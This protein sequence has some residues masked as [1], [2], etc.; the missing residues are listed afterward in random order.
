G[1]FTGLTP[2]WE[3]GRP[4]SGRFGPRLALVTTVAVTLKQ[5]VA[6]GTVPGAA[7]ASRTRLEETPRTTPGAAES[8]PSMRVWTTAPDTPPLTRWP[9][10][11]T[12]PSSRSTFAPSSIV[13]A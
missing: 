12:G 8:V 5:Y 3:G 7:S 4:R 6:P 11:A 9:L 1:A 2:R 13:R 10:P